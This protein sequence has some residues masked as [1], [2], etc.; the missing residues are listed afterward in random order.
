MGNFISTILFEQSIWLMAIPVVMIIFALLLW[1]NPLFLASWQ[2][3]SKTDS[4]NTY[5]LPTA[6]ILEKHI[7]KKQVSKTTRFF[8]QY[9]KYILFFTLILVALAQPYQ[10]GQK[11]PEPPRYHD[12]VFLVDASITMSLKDYQIDNKRI[13]RMT[14]VKNVLSH[15]IEK[16]Q[17]SRIGI[18]AFSEHA[19]TLS[20][21][22]A[23]YALL[24]TQLHRLEPAVLTGR[25]SNPSK[26]LLYTAKQYQNSK[27]K[28]VL[29]MLTDI[30]RP[31][32]QIDPRATASYLSQQG[33]HL[34]TIGIGAG[35]QAAK[36]DDVTSLI[37]Q[38]ANFQLLEQIASVAN[39][40]FF[41]A[42]T[43]AS[44]NL[45]LESIQEAETRIVDIQPEYV[46]EP[47]YMWLV[48]SALSWLSF[49][50]IVPLFRSKS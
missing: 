2:Q 40:Q 3:Q 39:G 5:Y 34:H 25:T 36:E 15:F 19:Y 13:A 45:A 14:I 48:I 32:R 31:D 4:K 30:D 9:I 47:L 10:K 28:P 26:A 11:L 35:S 29:V 18:T 6:E 49:W 43:I 42:K 33:F 20:P 16:L 27:K 12:I 17:G 38:P 8:S 7:D 37:Y 46:K 41:W 44:L 23:D 24:K 50:Q 21:L 1:K 22:T